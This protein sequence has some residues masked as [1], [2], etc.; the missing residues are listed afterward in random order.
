MDLRCWGFGFTGS[1]G[2]GFGTDEPTHRPLSSSVLG[3]PYRIL[4]I[5]HEKE[6]LRGLWVMLTRLKL[7][8]REKR[9]RPLRTEHF[10]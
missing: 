5:N 4:N 6:L 8:G 7:P 3:L 9:H 10:Y 2:V 1:F